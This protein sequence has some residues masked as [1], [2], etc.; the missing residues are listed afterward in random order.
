MSSDVVG[1]LIPEND[2]V[3]KENGT[4]CLLNSCESTGAGNDKE[5]EVDLSIPQSEITSPESNSDKVNIST[6]SLG[7]H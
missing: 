7:I 6:L 4:S 3:V 5:T 1:T 2:L